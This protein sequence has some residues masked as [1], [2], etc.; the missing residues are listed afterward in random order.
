[1]SG[2]HAPS[3]GWSFYASLTRA[4]VVGAVALGLVIAI[5]MVTLGSKETESAQPQTPGSATPTLTA[6]PS[7][8]PSP[9]SSVSDEP[10]P[11]PSPTETGPP[12]FN[13][14]ISVLNSTTRNGLAA[15]IRAKLVDEGYRR[16]TSGNTP[17]EQR[18]RIYYRPG[19]EEAA[20]AIVK[21]IPELGEP[22]EASAD[23]PKG[24]VVIILAKD[25]QG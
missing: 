8:S 18:T 9:T 3:S 21:L 16:V 5:V 6:S 17:P 19:A 10:T 14:S 23:T 7:V 22:V 20:D 11:S 13:L 12:G 1:M 4:V 15:R 24:A 2:K 25:F